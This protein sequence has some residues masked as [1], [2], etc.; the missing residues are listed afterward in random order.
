MFGISLTTLRNYMNVRYFEQLQA[1]G[2]QRNQRTI[3]PAVYSWLVEKLGHVE[4]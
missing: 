1:L 4:E 2:Y 3:Q